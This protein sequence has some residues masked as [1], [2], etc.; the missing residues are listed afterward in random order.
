MAIGSLRH[1]AELALGTAFIGH[2]LAYVRTAGRRLRR[3]RF[4]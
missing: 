3:Q 1:V 4:T 2:V